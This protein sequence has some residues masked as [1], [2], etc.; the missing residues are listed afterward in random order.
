MIKELKEKTF[1]LSWIYF[2]DF[3][4]ISIV[5]IPNPKLHVLIIN[6]E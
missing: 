2:Y 1:S 3:K 5:L 4:T 6:N